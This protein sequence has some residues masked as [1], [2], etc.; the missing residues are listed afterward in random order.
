M[1]HAV[2]CHAMMGGAWTLAA[3]FAREQ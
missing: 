3:S 1:D 2:H